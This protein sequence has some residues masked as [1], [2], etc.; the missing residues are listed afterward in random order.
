MLNFIAAAIT[1]FFINPFQ[2]V[3]LISRNVRG[4]VMSLFYFCNCDKINEYAVIVNLS[5]FTVTFLRICLKNHQY[6]CLA[7]SWT[8]KFS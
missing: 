6:S 8:K 3:C 5:C 2:T 7:T 4:N 1:N